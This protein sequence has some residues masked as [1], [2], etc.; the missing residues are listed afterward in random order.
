MTT[1]KI[2]ATAFT[3]IALT[4]ATATSTF[5][6]GGRHKGMHQDGEEHFHLV[7]DEMR[8]EFRSDFENLNDEERTALREERRTMHEERKAEFEGFVGLTKEE[9]RERHRNGETMSDILES[10][11]ITEEEAE[12]FFVTQANEKVDTIVE[13]HNLSEEEESTL[14]NR[15]SEFVQNIMN[16]FFGN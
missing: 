4:G 6:F 11:G 16:R 12:T 7:P 10:Q 9:L 15:I 2:L 3:V 8:E 1:K 14:R 5:A 13:K